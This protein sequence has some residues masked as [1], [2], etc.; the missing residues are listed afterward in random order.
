MPAATADGALGHTGREA[1][2]E[3]EADEM[4]KKLITTI[5]LVLTFAA[6]PVAVSATPA[7]AAPA[8]PAGPGACNMLHVSPTGMQRMLKASDQG[9]GNM[10][11]LVLASE[12]AGCPL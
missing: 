3:Q 12:A 7:A 11:E 9:L 6:A 4:S 10:M 5:A 8:T 1:E 2:P